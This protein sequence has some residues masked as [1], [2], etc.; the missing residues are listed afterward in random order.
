MALS[1]TNVKNL[2]KDTLVKFYTD[3][4]KPDL[5]NHTH[6]YAGSSTPG[7]A[8]TSANKVNSNLTLQLNGTT[9]KTYNGSSAQTFNVTPSGIGAAASNHTHN[10]AGSSSAGGAA[11]SANKLATA[12]KIGKASFNGESDISIG[13]ICNTVATTGTTTTNANKYTKIGS[14]NV[15]AGAYTACTGYLVFAPGESNNKMFGILSYYF[16]TNASIDSVS[17]SLQWEVLNNNDYK[18]CVYAVK[19]ANGKFDIYI[20]L[21][22]TYCTQSISTYPIVGENLI[23]LT[24]SQSYATSI[25]AVATSSLSHTY[26]DSTHTHA[27]LVI[28]GN[29]TQINTYNGGTAKTINIT[30]SNIGAATSGH[31][32]NYAGSSSAGGTATE[33]AKTTGTITIQ[34]NGKAIDTFNGSANKTI[35]ITPSNIGA[36]ASSHT[37]NYAGS[38]SAGGAATSANKVN[39]A[40]TIQGNGTALATFDGSSAKTVNIT[41]AN[42]GA[43]TS[44]HTHSNYATTSHSHGLLNNNFA[45][46]LSNTTTDSGWSMINS[47]YQGF[48]LTSLRSNAS[49][50]NWMLPNYASGIVFGGSDTKGVMSVSYSEP[51]VRFAGGAGTGPSWYYTLTG[52]KSKEY[53][54][55][56]F[57]T[58]TYVDTQLGDITSILEEIN[59]E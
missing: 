46:E 55:E 29:G 44:G 22:S 52:S 37:H 32:H 31:T 14:V 13:N 48:L 43:A 12:R 2:L 20:K 57:A 54:L 27:N 51:K 39:S 6:N 34:G 8:A 11:T 24:G 15:S 53:N 9:S 30:P 33:A 19:T 18:D 35:N 58:T 4:F 17:I 26:A 10:Y 56:S 45:K 28:Q 16:R 1:K 47:T 36:A 7:G 21:L 50:P 42:I 59:G 3:V 5:D 41:P 40:L 49:A 23:T 25:T 38:S